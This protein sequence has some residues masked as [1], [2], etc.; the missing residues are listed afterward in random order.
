MYVMEAD[1]CF[2]GV[3]NRALFLRRF[4]I[5]RARLNRPIITRQGNSTAGTITLAL[6]EELPEFPIV[7]VDVVLLTEGVYVR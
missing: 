7:L 4:C 5:H 1:S 6:F 3:G 2:K